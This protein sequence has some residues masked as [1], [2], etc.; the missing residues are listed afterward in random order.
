[1]EYSMNKASIQPVTSQAIKADKLMVWTIACLFLISLSIA[2]FN[3]SWFE[4]LSVGI[5]AML[6]PLLIIKLSPGT[7]RSRISVAFSFMVFSSLAIQQTHG[8]SES[9]FTVFIL[10]AFLLYYRDWR[11]IFVA[12]LAIAV[13]HVAFN[14]LQAGSTGVY[15][16]ALGPNLKVLIIHALAVVFESGL[17]ILMAT[18]LRAESNMLGGEP[19]VV[20]DIARRVAGGDLSVDIKTQQ[21]DTTSVNAALKSMV[22]H[23][24]SLI[25]SMDNMS[26]EHRAGNTDAVVDSS[27]YQ[28]SFKDVA[29]GVNT[30]VA[31]H[32]DMNNKAMAVV[33]AFGQGNFDVPLD[34]FSGKKA[35]INIVIEKV[36]GSIK[37]FVYD[38]KN[39]SAA[40]DK[41]DIDVRM[42][43]SKFVG[44]YNEMAQG[45]NDMVN[46][47]LDMN[48]KA[49]AVVDGF[50]EGNFNVSLE[51][52]P[53]KK[54]F[55]NVAIEKTRGNIKRFTSEM[56]QM[57]LA[58]NAGDIDFKM[59]EAQYNGTYQDMAH[60][61]NGMIA[62]HIKMN[63]DAIEVVEGFGHGDFTIQLEKLPGKKSFINE[64][65]EHVRSNL[66]QLSRDVEILSKASAEGRVTERADATKHP[67]EFRK[68]IE[69]FNATLESIVAPI[70]A[71]KRSAESINSV[72]KEIA[73][74]NNDLSTRTEQQASNLEKT[75]SSMEELAST[76]RKNAENAKQA[77]NLALVASGV[78]IKGGDVVDKV[79]G[80]MSAIN[81]SSKKIN[82]I[83]SVIDGIAFQTNILALNAAV[84]AARAGEQGRGFAVVAGEV[85]NLAQRS[86]T[87]AKEI[88]GL[89][90]DSVTKTAEGTE[91]VEL[92]G[93]TMKEVVSSVQ[94]V[95]DIMGAISTA[96]MEQS[97][98]IDLVNDA[99][100]SMDETTQ[101]NAALVEEAAAS[102]SLLVKQAS[103]L[104]EIVSGFK[105]ASN[106]IQLKTKLA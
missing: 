60:E 10:L 23:L 9:H 42:D 99:I 95:T 53:G 35:S 15:I 19:Q 77:N 55:I 18:S 4:A 57:S 20:A 96:S 36:R 67:G 49:I 87:A 1:M 54:A 21:G 93:K 61:L 104:S 51:P 85:R 24:S 29:L 92:A 43:E 98:G 91:Q 30:M 84:E 62:G 106:S 65:I 52:L 59:N 88:K 5:P 80:T 103:S 64:A 12:A 2:F 101:Q 11:P 70:M 38:M 28:G 46:G 37:N 63:K 22:E 69:G 40:H 72:A 41:G 105:L 94:R 45:L 48:R 3:G 16:F 32:I 6:I 83:I 76:V 39:M 102:A 50:G 86:A 34:K 81:T 26:S 82:E 27:L 90:A 79:V 25:S 74:G 58:H 73:V 75:A 7:L 97:S 33:E 13:H 17:L 47:H 68:V 8:M 78:A 66:L 14:F 71:V 56:N 44:T 89:I 100:A 31:G